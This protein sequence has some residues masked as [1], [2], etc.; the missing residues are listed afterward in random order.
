M[1]NGELILKIEI[2]EVLNLTRITVT[3]SFMTAES[4]KI[5]LPESEFTLICIHFIDEEFVK[6]LHG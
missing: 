6:L 2:N 1:Y 4:D 5:V 3:K